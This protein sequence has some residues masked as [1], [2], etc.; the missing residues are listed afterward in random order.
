MTLAAWVGFG[1]YFCLSVI[2]SCLM[3]A[4]LL[5]RVLFLL[6]WYSHEFIMCV[7]WR[8]KNFPPLFFFF[9]Q[10]SWAQTSWMD[11]KARAPSERRF[12][13]LPHC[14]KKS[15]YCHPVL[16]LAN[17]AAEVYERKACFSG[18]VACSILQKIW[19]VLHAAPWEV[20]WDHCTPQ[21]SSVRVQTLLKFPLTM[22]QTLCSGPLRSADLIYCLTAGCTAAAFSRVIHSVQA[23]E[24]NCDLHKWSLKAAKTNNQSN[25]FLSLRQDLHGTKGETLLCY[26]YGSL[27]PEIDCLEMVVPFWKWQRRKGKMRL[28]LVWHLGGILRSRWLI[29]QLLGWVPPTYSEIGFAQLQLH[30]VPCSAQLREQDI[31]T[32]PRLHLP[33]SPWITPVH[34]APVTTE[35]KEMIT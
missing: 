12:P 17:H 34:R 29:W 32:L 18:I 28:C 14:H 2:T 30:Q 22:A 8:I 1:Q 21:S 13:W 24:V 25:K 4:W 11:T 26:F 31:H 6:H 19:V 15:Y 35:T 16:L 10:S 5:G 23:M 33:C 27:S 3:T 20:T 7:C 9:F